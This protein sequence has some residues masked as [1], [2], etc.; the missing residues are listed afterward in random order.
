MLLKQN[1][2]PSFKFHKEEHLKSRTIIRRLF[3]EGKS[4]SVYPLRLVWTSIDLSL[5]TYPY[6]IQF[7]QTVPKRNFNKANKRNIIRRRI[8][9]AY[10]LNKHLIS[11]QNASL[12]KQYAWMFIY[13]AKQELPYAKIE[14]ATQKIIRRFIKENLPN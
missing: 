11:V 12:D 4:F 14:E 6:P 8:R 3:K 5:R 7:A 2:M 13:V 9:E 1:Y 10:R